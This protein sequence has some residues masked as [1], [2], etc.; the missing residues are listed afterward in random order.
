MEQIEET[1]KGG[2]EKD[3]QG[4][5]MVSEKRRSGAKVKNYHPERSIDQ[6]D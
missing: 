3:G 6:Q 5:A 1:W 4:K 2:A